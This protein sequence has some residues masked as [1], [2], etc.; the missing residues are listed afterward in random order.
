MR[1]L[2]ALVIVIVV[3]L[4]SARAATYYVDYAGGS[5]SNA[6]TSK[7]AP[8]KLHPFM[9]GFTGTYT[10]AAGD[11]F[12]F[13]G[14]VA[15]PNSVFPML[16]KGGGTS[17]G[18][19]YYGVDKTWFSG[20]SWTRPRFDLQGKETATT[21]RVVDFNNPSK[22][23]IT[24]QS[25]EVVGFYW[26]GPSTY[27]QDTM[28]YVYYAS[29]VTFDDMYIHNY[30]HGPASDGTTD[31]MRMFLGNGTSPYSPGVVLQNCV[32][33]GDGN[34]G[35]VAF[36]IPTVKGCTISNMPNAIVGAVLVVGNTISKVT[37]S[38]DPLQHENGI[39]T[40]RPAEVYNNVISD[41]EAGVAILS[42]PCFY[43]KSSGIT[44]YDKI[45]NNVIYTSSPV[46]IQVDTQYS[47]GTCGA[48]VWNNTLT[49]GSF[50]AGSCI[51]AVPRT[52]YA[53]DLLVM[54]NNQCISTN[55]SLACYNVTACGTVNNV[56]LDHNLLQTPLTAAQQGYSAS[57]L[58]KPVARGGTIGAGTNA[59]AAQFTADR[60]RNPRPSAGPWD[61]GAY[62]F[63]SPPPPQNLISNPH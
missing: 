19:D 56:T 35:F 20:A 4:G 10:H 63:T 37:S 51:R 14:G 9:V 45:Y 40:F 3:S 7:T 60:I 30:S 8:W 1:R 50:G 27:G 22:N 33:E 31:N 25:I 12:I 29:N 6:G 61:I 55:T 24:F 47:L 21:N 5:D 46:P 38:F 53:L 57:N 52:G 44:G 23:F 17:A 26:D 18:F 28:F 34:S 49:G 13:K 15:W 42:T 36:N 43:A 16:L 58:L 59:P 41:I 2:A 39:E 32:V 62:Q 11:Q 48:F 54:Q